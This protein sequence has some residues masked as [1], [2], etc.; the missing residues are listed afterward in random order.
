M[1]LA[2]TSLNNFS[3]LGSLQQLLVLCDS[4]RKQGQRSFAKL[5]QPHSRKPKEDWLVPAHGKLLRGHLSCGRAACVP[6]KTWLPCY[7]FG[8]A[9][10]GCS[11]QL[12]TC[13]CTTTVAPASFL[14]YSCHLTGLGPTD[15]PHVVSHLGDKGSFK[16]SK[17]FLWGAPSPP[18]SSHWCR[19]WVQPCT[20]E[21]WHYSPNRVSRHRIVV[22]ANTCLHSLREMGKRFWK[23]L[24]SLLAYMLKTFIYTSPHQLF[25]H[26][27]GHL[28]G[29]VRPI[30]QPTFLL[31]SLT[32]NIKLTLCSRTRAPDFWPCC[33]PE[34]FQEDWL[35]KWYFLFT[36]FS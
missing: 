12:G 27:V 14:P 5:D 19:G 20:L 34:G 7:G 35:C 24:F 28:L 36:R 26:G 32:W 33:F 18:S 22:G 29:Y 17:V 6:G 3:V 30:T 23:Y 16:T 8:A 10:R 13:S 4:Y 2:A 25:A 1:F 9:A 11:L 31:N 15:L 21:N